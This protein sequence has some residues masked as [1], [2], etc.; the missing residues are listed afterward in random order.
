MSVN[1][2]VTPNPNALKFTVGELVG[3]P[4]TVVKGG[5]A[6]DE[7]A[8]QLVELEGVTSVFFT[9]DFVTVSKTADAS[10]DVITPE[11]TAILESHFST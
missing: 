9:A 4:A 11:A 3:G 2:E 6:D 1:I 5:E 7:F 8:A 10:W